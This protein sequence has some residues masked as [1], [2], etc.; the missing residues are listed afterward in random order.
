MSRKTTEEVE[1]EAARIFEQHEQA[2]KG[3]VEKGVALGK[4]IKWAD[5]D[6][7]TRNAWR[8]IALLPVALLAL[9]CGSA[10]SDTTPRAA[11]ATD[12]PGDTSL[13]P[14][15]CE[16][17]IEAAKLCAGS[18]DPAKCACLYESIAAL[19]RWCCP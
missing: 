15:V 5:T 10:P 19:P 3:R 6:P 4:P 12:Y 17:D 9:A 11:G 1:A 8:V 13:A 16:D 18:T 14:P 2:W 7:F